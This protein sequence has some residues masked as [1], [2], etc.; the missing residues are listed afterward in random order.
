[1]LDVVQSIVVFMLG[2]VAIIVL[3]S[4]LIMVHKQA[5]RVKD[6][7]MRMKATDELE[8]NQI[9]EGDEK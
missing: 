4:V 6:L 2:I 9:I 1:M 5:G 3:L 7:E 8:A